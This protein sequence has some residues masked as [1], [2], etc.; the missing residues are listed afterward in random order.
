MQIARLNE[1]LNGIQRSHHPQVVAHEEPIDLE[2]TSSEREA[3]RDEQIAIDV[4]V[5]QVAAVRVEA[6][7]GFE[8]GRIA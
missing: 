3:A 7:N 6:M 4:E 8:S 2:A 5:G 1:H